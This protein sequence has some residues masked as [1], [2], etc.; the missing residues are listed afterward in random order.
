MLRNYKFF[1]NQCKFIYNCLSVNRPLKRF[2]ASILLALFLFNLWGFMLLFQNSTN[3][4]PASIINP[5]SN[6]YKPSDLVEIKVPVELPWDYNWDTY[7]RI[8]GQVQLDKGNYNYVEMKITHDTLYLMC[9]PNYDKTKLVNTNII[10]A[11]QVSDLPLSK[12]SH[13]RFPKVPSPDNKYHYQLAQLQFI[14]PVNTIQLTNTYILPFIDHPLV[15]V[16]GQPPEAI[17]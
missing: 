13:N 17:V 12:K 6:R 9:L 7:E 15:P 4:S 1:V 10:L 3:R 2:V 11:K 5:V 8:N 14:P 16:N